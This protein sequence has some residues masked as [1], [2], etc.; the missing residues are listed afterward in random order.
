V[1]AGAL[2]YHLA[3]SEGRAGLPSR[4]RA[5]A[6]RLARSHLRVIRRADACWRR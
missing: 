1:L 6:V 5:D 2:R 3:V 4:V